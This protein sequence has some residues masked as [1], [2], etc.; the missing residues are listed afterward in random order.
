MR[1][2]TTQRGFG[3]VAAM[4]LIIIIAAVIAAMARLALTQTATNSL[5]IQQARAYQAARAGLE[6][7]IVQAL[8]GSACGNFT[9]DGFVV[10][11]TCT[12]TPAIAVSEENRTVEFFTISATAQYGGVG[13]PDYAFRS[14]TAV[15]ER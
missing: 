14:L 9:L 2:E 10:A 4:F 8:A 1:P 15:V 11:V 3:L 7:G 6:Y 12:P 5:A 13:A